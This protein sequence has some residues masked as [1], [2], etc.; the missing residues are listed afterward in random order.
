MTALLESSEV[1]EGGKFP[2]LLVHKRGGG[3]NICWTLNGDLTWSGSLHD[4]RQRPLS[5][6]RKREIKWQNEWL[7]LETKYNINS[8]GPS[9]WL[10]SNL[11]WAS[12]SLLQCK[13]S[14]VN[15]CRVFHGHSLSLRIFALRGGFYVSYRHIGLSMSCCSSDVVSKKSISDY[16]LL[17]AIKIQVSHALSPIKL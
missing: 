7:T 16:H 3:G 4:S 17:P 15:Y 14:L 5:S 2:Q 6:L 11:I 9:R 13:T 10:S 12:P 1:S 8:Y